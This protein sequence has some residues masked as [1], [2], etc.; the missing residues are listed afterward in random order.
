MTGKWILEEFECLKI[1]V[2][3]IMKYKISTIY[4][5]FGI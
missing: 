5:Q 3:L 1:S 4:S 2:F